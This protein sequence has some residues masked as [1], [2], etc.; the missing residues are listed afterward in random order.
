M[1]DTTISPEQE[2]EMR[3]VKAH[4][5]YRVVCGALHPESGEF[6]VYATYDRRKANGLARKGWAVFV[7]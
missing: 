5:P 2:Q 1:T 4:F 3:Q 7:L 6:E